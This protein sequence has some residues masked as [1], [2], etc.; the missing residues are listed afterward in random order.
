[1][2]RETYQTEM[3]RG[4][5][6]KTKKIKQNKNN[7][8]TQELWDNFK[9]WNTYTIEIAEGEEIE[10]REEELSEMLMVDDFPKLQI[11]EAQIP[12]CTNQN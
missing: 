11:Q 9:R 8:P 10:N 12:S 2:S 3:Q 6:I 4:K 7:N 1:M 5:T